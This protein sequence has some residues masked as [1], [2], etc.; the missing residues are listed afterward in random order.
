MI[1][2]MT[3]NTTDNM[4]SNMKIL[5][6]GSG[7]REHAI[8]KKLSESKKVSKLYCAPGN[9]GISQLAECIDIDALDIDGMVDFSK[10]NSIDLVV[11]APEAPL[12][13]GMADALNNIGIRAFGPDADAAMIE[14]SKVFSKN[15]M[16]KYN[17]P[18][19]AYEIFTDSNSALNYLKS[20]KYPIVIKADGLAA[21]KGVI[22]ANNYN[23]AKAAFSDIMGNKIFGD[24][25]NKVVVEEFLTGTEVSILAFTDGKTIYPM[26]SAKDHKKIFD[27]DE[28]PNTG[29]MGAISPSL[30]YTKELADICMKKIFKPTVDAM[31]AENR[32]FKG[33]L[34]F[35]LM[36]T[37][38]GPKVI[39]YNCRFGDPETQVVLPRLK[40]DLV[41]IFEAV[42]DE[43]LDSINIEW[44]DNAAACVV[45]ASG[46]YPG[47]YEKGYVIS[48]M[49]DALKLKDIYVYHAGTKKTMDGEFVTDGGRV[50]GV[51]ATG[52]NL[53]EAIEKAYEAVGKI[54]FKDAHFRKDIGKKLYSP[55]E[56][57][58][59][60]KITVFPEIETPNI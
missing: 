18:T 46:G 34:F 16:K 20:S 37:D 52:G 6:I 12:S 32:K 27:N 29:G 30:L 57:S 23:E 2:K 49:E 44:E 43:K 22:I 10:K 39:E 45:M 35:G 53:G 4:T 54:F 28:G 14:S 60:E 25:G 21:G 11:V 7:G 42:I 9:G 8:V 31:N 50:I 56:G 1:E 59:A 41:D 19:A 36:I 33:V 38:E 5:V 47:N 3:D 17:I 51:T 55:V 26:V 15:L 24:S 48:G 58:F 40:N 13:K